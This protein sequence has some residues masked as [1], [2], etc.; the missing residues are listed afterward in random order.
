ML[1][2]DGPAQR[3]QRFRTPH[4]PGKQASQEAGQVTTGLI[5]LVLVAA[6]ITYGYTRMRRR[7]GMA[8]TGRHWLMAMVA[9]ILAILALWAYSTHR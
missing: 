9:T 2:R 4:P 6:L 7:M 8:V 1:V 3:V 5:L